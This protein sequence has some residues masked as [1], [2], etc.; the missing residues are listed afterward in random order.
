[1]TATA[2]ET[3]TPTIVPTTTVPYIPTH[4]RHRVLTEAQIHDF[5]DALDRA[6]GDVEK[7]VEKAVNTLLNQG[8]SSIYRAPVTSTYPYNTDGYIAA[9]DAGNPYALLVEAKNDMQFSAQGKHDIATVLTQVCWYLRAIGQAG[10]VVPTVSVVCDSDEIFAIP[11]VLLK[12]HID[13]DYRWDELSASSMHKDAQLMAALIQD[14]NIR[15]YVHDVTE[16]FDAEM[17]IWAVDAMGRGEEPIK[18]PVNT[19][20]MAVSYTHLTLPTKA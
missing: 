12:S 19:V 15:P 13:G 16:N 6:S 7:T 18:V 1:M 8:L 5:I 17:F 2:A 3:A 14:P 10:D 9:N 11:T 20:S 4:H